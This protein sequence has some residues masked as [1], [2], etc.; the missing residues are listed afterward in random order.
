MKIKTAI[1]FLKLPFIN[2]KI[3]FRKIFYKIKNIYIFK[4]VFKQW[5]ESTKINVACP[6]CSSDKSQNVSSLDRHGL[7]V[8][9]DI[10]RSCGFV[11]TNPQPPTSFY[12][13][14]YR[15]YYWV[16]YFGSETNH[17][18]LIPYWRH[19]ADRLVNSLADLKICLND[20][21]VFEVGCGPGYTIQ[22]LISRWNCQ[23]DALEPSE[24]ECKLL[25]SFLCN[26]KI[27]N[28]TIESANASEIV[29]R[30]YYDFVISTHVIE[31]VQN[32]NIAFQFIS[33]ILK[34]S[35]FA[36]IEVPDLSY[37]GWKY[38]H[39]FHIA[40]L[41]HFTEA[42]LTYMAA[43]H[44]LQKLS[45]IRGKNSCIKN[46]GI[47]ILFKKDSSHVELPNEFNKNLE[48]LKSIIK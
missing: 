18:N 34:N 19:Q 1:Y 23:I 8:K 43:K 40:H 21:N 47:G 14:F 26:S 37:S 2:V 35:G 4:M 6:I 25:R 44:G 10:C 29:P 30:N 15:K 45:V 3:F 42:N 31:H 11:F 16:L 46:S 17:K 36:Y 9:T 12:E 7:C 48:I 5:T 22:S 28:F 27:F 41:W 20:K 13:K 39:I 38:P 24:S 32:P 33:S